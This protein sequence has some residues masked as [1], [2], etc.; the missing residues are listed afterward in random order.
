M[1]INIVSTLFIINTLLI[2]FLTISLISN[3][4]IF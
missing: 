1:Y 3:N 4:E 2:M